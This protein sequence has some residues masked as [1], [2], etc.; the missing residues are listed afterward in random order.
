MGPRG[1]LR[2][3]GRMKHLTVIDFETEYPI[4]LDSRHP[5]VLR[6]PIEVYQNKTGTS[7][8]GAIS[9]AQIKSK[10]GP[11]GDEKIKKKSHSVENPKGGTL[12]THPLL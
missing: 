8:V 10:G 4:I 3:T 7:Q 9:K 5:V 11:F 6:F 1:R 2:S 12:Y